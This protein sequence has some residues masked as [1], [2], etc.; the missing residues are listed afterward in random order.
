MMAHPTRIS[1]IFTYSLLGVRIVALTL[2]RFIQHTDEKGFRGLLD[3]ISCNGREQQRL[4]LG[5]GCGFIDDWI[6]THIPR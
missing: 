4:L 1:A 3:R 5:Y 2:A 6:W